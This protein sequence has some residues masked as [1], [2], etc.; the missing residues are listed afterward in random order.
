MAG[1]LEY[2]K[3][4]GK[5]FEYGIAS[6]EEA[7]ETGGERIGRIVTFA[8]E[9]AEEEKPG[10]VRALQCWL[11]KLEYCNMQ[12]KRRSLGGGAWAAE[13]ERRSLSLSNG[14]REFCFR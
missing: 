12:Q 7:G 8:K 6:L 14:F 1:C 13:L 3:A 5:T 10:T 2:G 4:S 11:Q 9:P